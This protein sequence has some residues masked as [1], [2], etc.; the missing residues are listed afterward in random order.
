MSARI[1]NK[2]IWHAEDSAVSMN[3]I[4][5][6]AEGLAPVDLLLLMAAQENDAPRIAELLRAGAD[7]NTKVCITVSDSF[8][9]GTPAA[10]VS[11][12]RLRVQ[13]TS[14]NCILNR[15]TV[16]KA[17]TWTA[18]KPGTHGSTLAALTP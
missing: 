1:K 16:F 8:C 7:V 10:A 12:L 6:C 13:H 5:L 14:S 17:C 11:A 18:R 2:A 3:C 4:L 9:K 15:H